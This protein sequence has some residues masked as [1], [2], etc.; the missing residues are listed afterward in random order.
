MADTL[1]DKIVDETGYSRCV[2]S[3][4]VGLSFPLRAA[5]IAF[6]NAYRVILIQDK[7]KLVGLISQANVVAEQIA[8]V[9]NAGRAAMAPFDT[10]LGAI[11]FAQ[12]AENCPLIVGEMGQ[13]IDALPTQIPSTFI[14]QAAN[15]DGFDIFAGVTDYNS[16]TNK[17]DE[18]AFR[19]QRALSASDRLSKQSAELDRALELMDQ[20]LDILSRTQ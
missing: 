8:V 9:A 11:P 6:F 10:I 2:V 1:V 16:M 12:M 13:I 20:Y 15:I 18:L 14:S 5:L 19:S 7:A 3:A 4:L 17:L